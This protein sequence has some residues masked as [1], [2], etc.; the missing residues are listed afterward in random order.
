MTN[1]LRWHRPLM[2][3]TAAMAVLAVIA[4]IGVFTDP[5]VLTGAPIWLKPFKFA[6]SFVAYGA[7]LAWMLS[8]LPRRSR[9]AEIAATV[10]L[11][12]SVA[13]IVVIVTQVLRGT[14]SHYNNSTPLNSALFQVM[15][16]SILILFMAHFVLGFVI[17][18]ARLADRVSAHAVRWGLGL[19]LVGMLAAVPMVMPGQAPPGQAPPGFDDVSGAHSVGVADGGP[20]LPLVGWSTTGGD[21][22][23]GHFVGL[24]A[25]QVL[26]LLALLLG[27]RLDQL[28]RVRLLLVGGCAYGIL[29]VLLTWQALRG[30]PLLRPDALTLTA[31]AALAV[32]V[33]A[34]TVAV[35]A[36]RRRP[37]AG[38]AAPAIRA[39]KVGSA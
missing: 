39:D 7:T 21:L 5:R 2:V 23:I 20:G 38:P 24:H 35:L 32:S 37:D 19:S 1:V 27:T 18:R 13:E 36:R 25:L 34:A 11:A 17:L 33:A 8:L 30:Q 22:R 6:V 28:T 4:G 16:T 3:F 12:T 26:P 31:W 15:G 29:V 10:I 9:V 14:T